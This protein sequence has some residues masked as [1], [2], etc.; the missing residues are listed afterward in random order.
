MFLLISCQLTSKQFIQQIK[1]Q[2]S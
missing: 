1:D 2:R